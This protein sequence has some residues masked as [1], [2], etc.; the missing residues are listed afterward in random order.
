M[1]KAFRYLKGEAYLFVVN[2]IAYEIIAA[3]LWKIETNRMG[4]SY[5]DLMG[6]LSGISEVVL[7]RKGSK[8]YRWSTV[9]QE[10]QKLL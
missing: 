6:K 1:E 7:I 10:M 2:F 8:I 9:S 4:I 3:I 5:E